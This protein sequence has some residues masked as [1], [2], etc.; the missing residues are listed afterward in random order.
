MTRTMARWFAPLAAVVAGGAFWMLSH[1][2]A[3][4]SMSVRGFADVVDHP[5]GPLGAGRVSRVM[6]S[7]GQQV[8]VG[9]VLAAM[10]ARELELKR[11][12]AQSALAQSKAALEAAE[13][14]AR[15]AM[16]RAELLVLKTQSS[17]RQHEAEL[18]EVKNQLARLEKLAGERLVQ[19]QDVERAKVQ[20]A[21][22]AAGIASFEA[23]TREHQAGLGR[24]LRETTTNQQVAKLLEPLREGLNQKEDALKLAELALEEATVRSHVDGI[25]T[26]VLHHEGD[27][28]SAGTEVVR[29]VTARKG[30]V[31]CWLP[32]RLAGKVATGAPVELRG[33]GL[34]QGHFGGRVEELA[35]EIEEVPVRARISAAVPAWG[36]RALIDASPDRPLIPGEALHVRF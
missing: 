20:E 5:V 30:L 34:F 23:A 6:V 25:V 18:V 21:Q 32:E 1:G 8:H 27:V 31:V 15:L 16:A 11:A 14:N 26:Q 28:V 12:T 13:V 36:R 2:G 22:L 24:A 35:P 29:I 19:A 9:D 17:A 33:M 3:S 7:V 4:S 10:E